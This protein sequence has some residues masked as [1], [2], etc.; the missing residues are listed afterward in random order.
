MHG[1]KKGTAQ[2]S[3]ATLPP[4]VLSDLKNTSKADVVLLNDF[5]AEA[6]QIRES[7]HKTETAP[8]LY[9]SAREEAG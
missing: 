4:D 3:P 9:P 5:K 6:L 2:Q 7:I 1:G 8:K